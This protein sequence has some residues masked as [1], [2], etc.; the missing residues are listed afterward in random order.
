MPFKFFISRL[1]S[2][3]P[4]KISGVCKQMLYKLPDFSGVYPP[5]M[6]KW[7]GYMQ[8]DVKSEEST[9]ETDR[10]GGGGA[11]DP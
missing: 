9:G 7:K 10:E 8:S 11:K 5:K 1:Q 4:K 3:E 6:L 2:D